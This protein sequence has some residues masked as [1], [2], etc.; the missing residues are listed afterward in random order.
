MRR[1]RSHRDSRLRRSGRDR[2]QPLRKTRRRDPQLS[3]WPLLPLEPCRRLCRRVPALQRHRD[4]PRRTRAG[5]A[6]RRGHRRA[7]ALQAAGLVVNI[8]SRG[9]CS[10]ATRSGTGGTSCRTAA[11]SSASHQQVGSALAP[12]DAAPLASATSDVPPA[13]TTEARPR[14]HPG[15]SHPAL[16]DGGRRGT[17]AG[18]GRGRLPARCGRQHVGRRVDGGS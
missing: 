18:G 16:R 15:A 14:P 3:N 8:R 13:S 9:R 11:F 10:R 5:L 7:R 1:S 17:S 12:D 4:R 6:F 2:C